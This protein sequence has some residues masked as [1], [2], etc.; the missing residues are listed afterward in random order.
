M[1][2]LRKKFCIFDKKVVERNADKWFW[3]VFTLLY[4]EL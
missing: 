2:V 4:I 3:L 1:Q